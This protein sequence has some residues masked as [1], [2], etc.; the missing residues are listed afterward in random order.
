MTTFT[1]HRDTVQAFVGCMHGGADKDALSG[2]LA[3]DVVLYGPLG[4]DPLTGR[5][6]V[7]GAMQ[8]V[9]AV[10]TDLTY[11]EVLSGQTHH[12]AYFRLQ[13]EDTV[14]DGMDYILLDEGG[15]ISEVTIWWRPLPFG[16]QMQRRLAGLLGMQPWELRTN[17][18]T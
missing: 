14:V 7:L 6:A 10:A 9:G 18:E 15:K 8:G 5:E 16:V 17:D 1:P 3:E 11:Q 2:L 4:D 12:A 13:V